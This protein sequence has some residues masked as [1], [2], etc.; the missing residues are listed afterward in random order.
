MQWSQAIK[1]TSSSEIQSPRENSI[2]LK[3]SSLL[4]IVTPSRS[5]SV[6]DRPA[7]HE[8]SANEKSANEPVNVIPE[9][10][11][12]A[13]VDKCLSISNDNLFASTDEVYEMEQAASD[14]C[15]PKTNRTVSP[16]SEY[17]SSQHEHECAGSRTLTTKSV[18]KSQKNSSQEN[19][20]SI[21][22]QDFSENT[23]S[24]NHIEKAESTLK[25]NGVT[26]SS[27]DFLQS[28][29]SRSEEQPKI[30]KSPNQ[31]SFLVSDRALDEMMQAVEKQK[32]NEDPAPIP[33][34]V[35]NEKAKQDNQRT[36]GGSNCTKS[37]SLFSD[38]SFLDPQVCSILE[39]NVVDPNCFADFEKSDFTQQKMQ[40]PDK[41]TDN[42][43]AQVFKKPSAAIP[44]L[45]ADNVNT[46]GQS[47]S[48]VEKN[49]SSEKLAQASGSKQVTQPLTWIEDS[50]DQTKNLPGNATTPKDLENKQD[51]EEQS[52]SLLQPF[53]RKTRLKTV[54][55]TQAALSKIQAT[56]RQENSPLVGTP[57]SILRHRELDKMRE[58]PIKS[59]R[60]FET[61]NQPCTSR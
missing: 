32:D 9:R 21:H 8:N 55:A 40:L 22:T 51:A 19:Y 15:R 59:V 2:A 54:A 14:E 53:R 50:W 13:S 58:S 17:A 3:S 29:N 49:S 23:N 5:M 37:P 42:S 43:A 16:S 20:V 46:I 44:D 11:S 7:T 38:S 41:R 25:K 57:K 31:E 4:S 61:R 26:I 6:E 47:I 36:S 10:N 56:T 34:P 45:A 60:S 24:S 33:L 28:M 1:N 18:E 48:E 39:Q 30:N 12:D 27:Q 52:P 35:I